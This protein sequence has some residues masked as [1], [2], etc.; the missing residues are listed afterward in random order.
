MNLTPQRF[1]RA[2]YPASFRILPRFNDV[3]VNGHLNNAAIGAIYE[4]ARLQMHLQLFGPQV[5]SNRNSASTVVTDVR[6]LFL[7]PATYP[8]P[9]SIFAAVS[10]IA[11][12]SY[13][14]CFALYQEESC[15]GFCESTM[16][17]VVG[18]KAIALQSDYAS[19][20]S[21]LSMSVSKEGVPDPR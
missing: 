12:K 21:T 18:G 11:D 20:L 7:L 14:V 6:I 4:E 16:M 1:D 19:R 9:L 8:A 10:S 13:V 17:R 3:D 15:I 2:N 5:L